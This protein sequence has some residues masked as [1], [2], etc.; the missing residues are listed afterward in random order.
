M[1]S[2]PTSS[3]PKSSFPMRSHMNNHVETTRSTV[4]P[5]PMIRRTLPGYAD[6]S[7]LAWLSPDPD[8]RRFLVLVHGI[9]RQA[10]YIM[11]AFVGAAERYNYSLL[12]PVFTYRTYPDYQ[13][14]G[15]SGLG[16]RADLAFMGMIDDA[17]RRLGMA[18]EF[19]LFGFSGGA[20][21]AHR[22]AYAHPGV[23]RS[24]VFAAAG[25]YTPPDS[26]KRFPYGLRRT[27][28]LPGARFDADG[29][30]S[31]PTLTMVGDRDTQRDDM[32]RQR[33]IV[34]RVQGG[35]RLARARW[36]HRTLSQ[37]TIQRGFVDRHE[38]LELPDTGHD[39]ATAVQAGGLVE[40]TLS[41]CD[42]QAQ[43]Y[44]EEKLA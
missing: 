40:A 8:P 23:A 20:Q 6:F 32:L 42:R 4:P 10:D 38:F 30:L 14:L 22:L 44:P 37:L 27:R 33:D 3:F 43:P 35:H 21:F 36:F 28:R 34:D 9:A 7:Y 12:A 1:S 31:T 24:I 19:D 15:R 16:E 29:I 39:F 18:P 25:W 2:L 41:F 11:R 13:R 5:E 26:P 17:A